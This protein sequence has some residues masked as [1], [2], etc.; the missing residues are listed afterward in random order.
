MTEVVEEYEEY[1]EY[2]EEY[3]IEGEMEEEE[4]EEIVDEV[5][6]C[7][8][9]VHQ[10]KILQFH[11]NA[12]SMFAAKMRLKGNDLTGGAGT[13]GPVAGTMNSDVNDLLQSAVHRTSHLPLQTD[14]VSD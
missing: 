2:E 1:E 11:N 5:S 13:E 14:P 3:E 4:V 8:L 7:L 6:G 9:T 12:Y 10:Q